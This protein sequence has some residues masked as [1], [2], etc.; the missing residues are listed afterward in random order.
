[1][2]QTDISDF[3]A[4]APWTISHLIGSFTEKKILIFENKTVRLLDHHA[5]E[6][7]CEALN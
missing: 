5:L 4:L 6:H 7:A 2:P 3:L 1:M